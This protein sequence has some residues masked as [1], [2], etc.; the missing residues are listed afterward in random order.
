MQDEGRDDAT[1]YAAQA[2]SI[3]GQHMATILDIIFQSEEKEKEG[4]ACLL[5]KSHL[6]DELSSRSLKLLNE[7]TDPF[8]KNGT[9]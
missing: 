5:F 9:F 3:L 6:F 4:D 7:S 1:K 8:T 2:L